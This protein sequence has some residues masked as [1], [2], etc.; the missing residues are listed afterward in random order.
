MKQWMKSDISQK[1]VDIIKIGDRIRTHRRS[2]NLFRKGP[3]E[4]VNLQ[5]YH[6][7]GM[8]VALIMTV[9]AAVLAVHTQ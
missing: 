2:A 4:G 5:N 9:H 6:D 8:N 1:R 3:I 7:C